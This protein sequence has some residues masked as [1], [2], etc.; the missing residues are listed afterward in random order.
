MMLG[1]FGRLSDRDN[2]I[3]PIQEIAKLKS[4]RDE[5]AAPAP[6]RKRSQLPLYRNVG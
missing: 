1:G 3:D 4:F 2:E 6:P 5:F